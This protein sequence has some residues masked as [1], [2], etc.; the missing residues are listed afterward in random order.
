MNEK[1]EFHF[2]VFAVTP[3]Q[4]KIGDKVSIDVENDHLKRMQ[5]VHFS[6]A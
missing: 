1:Q 3:G 5:D 6:R 2:R 4:T